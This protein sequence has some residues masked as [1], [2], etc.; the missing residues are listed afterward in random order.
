MTSKPGGRGGGELFPGPNRVA[1]P[2]RVTVS[3]LQVYI[4][5][6]GYHYLR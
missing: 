4:K 3:R 5:G 6:S 1:L 2:E